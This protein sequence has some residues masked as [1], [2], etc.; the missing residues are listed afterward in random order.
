MKANNKKAAVLIVTGAILTASPLGAGWFGAEHV[1][2]APVQGQT[3][4]TSL[5]QVDAAIIKKAQAYVK[6]VSGLDLTFTALLDIPQLERLTLYVKDSDNNETVKVTVHSKTG[7]LQNFYVEITPDQME[8]AMKQQLNQALKDILGK[9]Q[10]FFD[11]L[12]HTGNSLDRITTMLEAGEYEDCVYGKDAWVRF[13]DKQLETINLN[14]AP[15]SVNSK[16]LAASSKSLITLG[17]KP[18]K[19]TAARYVKG[20][21]DYT[22]DTYKLTYGEEAEAEIGAKTQTVYS[23]AVHASQ[24]PVYDPK[25]KQLS[26]DQ[27]LKSASTATKQ[28]YGLDLKGYTVAKKS[29]SVIFSKKGAPTLICSFT[30]SGV[31]YSIAL[32]PTSAVM[33]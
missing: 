11:K 18:S 4:K 30:S 32:D 6:Q 5:S 22:V 14:V 33:N 20:Y 25:A 26:N 9:E 27:L 28:I 16:V 10:I 7:E 31:L 8:A 21:G 19:P 23:L 17:Y 15:A 24:D 13:V 29:T 12:Y 1:A 3:A 2:A